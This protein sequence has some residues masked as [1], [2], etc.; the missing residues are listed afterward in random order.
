MKALNGVLA[1]MVLCAA[2]GAS[3]DGLGPQALPGPRNDALR[4]SS[5][6]YGVPLDLLMAVAYQQGRF[7]SADAVAPQ[8]AWAEPSGKWALLE[9]V[10]PDEARG[11]ENFPGEAQGDGHAH[12]E[13][14]GLM[15][16]DAEQ[17]QRAALR[18]GRSE[19]D[20]A[21]DLSLNI[22][23]SA[24]LLCD[25]AQEAG[26]RDDAHFVEAAI[27][28]VG[29]E[30]EGDAASLARQELN[31]LRRYGFEITTQDGERLELLGEPRPMQ[32]KQGLAA[33]EYPPIQF[34]PA[35]ATNYSVGR[36]G[37]ETVRYVVIHD[38]EGSYAGA[39]QVFQNAARQASA[40]YVIRASDGHIAQMVNEANTAWHGG[41]AYFNATSIGIEH[42]GFA[43][44]Q[45]G[46]GA[47]N[48]SKQY[49]VSSQLVCAIAKKYGIPVDRKHIFGHG[50]IP[51]ANASR[52]LCSDDR[53]YVNRLGGC[54]GASAHSDPGRF[55]DFAK[56]M[57]LVAKCVAAATPTPIPG[58]A[59]ANPVNTG[60]EGDTTAPGQASSTGIPAAPN[61]GTAHREEMLPDAVG[62][63]DATGMEGGLL[64]LLGAV[65]TVTRRRSRKA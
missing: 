28:L 7:E 49:G 32:V 14:F 60:I 22:E 36:N 51:S 42:E 16:L 41:H 52:V 26:G 40:H 65:L 45:D 53:A 15:H 24:A 27:R 43:G 13:T 19:R 39:V 8:P 2:C 46:G 20:V 37:N 17:L 58:V 44:Q 11:T 33:G 3:S 10:T 6:T 25:Y 1:A 5:E 55:W 59:P 57:D 29:L 30:P 35:A 50:N 21:S 48:F 12:S 4:A 62:G 23:A 56:Y 61:G 64:G 31:A 54:G 9:G 34:I 63:C 47:G 18:I 38:I